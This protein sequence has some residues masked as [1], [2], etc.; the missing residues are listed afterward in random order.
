MGDGARLNSA[1]RKLVYGPVLENGSAGVANAELKP[2]SFVSLRANAMCS[3]SCQTV[4]KC[5]I[6]AMGIIQVQLK[7]VLLRIRLKVWTIK[8]EP[9]IVTDALVAG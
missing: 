9:V 4:R 8:K 7:S 5:I 2:G 6:P 1:Q 3:Q